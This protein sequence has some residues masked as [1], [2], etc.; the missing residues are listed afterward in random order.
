MILNTIGL[1]FKCLLTTF[2][3]FLIA[4]KLRAR[5][6]SSPRDMGLATWK[7]YS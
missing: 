3:F 6:I 1:L 4:K 2:N 7:W 5:P